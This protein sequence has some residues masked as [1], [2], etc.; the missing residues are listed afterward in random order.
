MVVRIGPGDCGG[1]L[2]ASL[3]LIVEVADVCRLNILGFFLAF[4]IGGFTKEG[5]EGA[6][7]WEGGLSKPEFSLRASPFAFLGF[8]GEG[9]VIGRS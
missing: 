8:L 2:L 1:A 3:A 6:D 7:A 4:G 9:E 5:D